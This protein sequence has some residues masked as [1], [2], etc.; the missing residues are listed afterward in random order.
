MQPLAL[1]KLLKIGVVF[2][3]TLPEDLISKNEF[4]Q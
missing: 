4:M 2:N 1:Q 3:L